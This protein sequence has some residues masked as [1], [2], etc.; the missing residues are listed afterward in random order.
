MVRFYVES[1]NEINF[2][3]KTSNN[4]GRILLSSTYFPLVELPHSGSSIMPKKNGQE[5]KKSYNDF[6]VD[7]HY[8]ILPPWCLGQDFRLSWL[9]RDPDGPV[10]GSRERRTTSVTL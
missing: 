2:N 7:S 4:L 1:T 10:L 9:R 5:E 6:G 8:E 3:H